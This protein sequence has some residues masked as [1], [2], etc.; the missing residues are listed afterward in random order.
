[1]LGGCRFHFSL[2]VPHDGFIAFIFSGAFTAPTNQVVCL[3]KIE[4]LRLDRTSACVTEFTAFWMTK[5]VGSNSNRQPNPA[6]EINKAE[7]NLKL[8]IVYVYQVLYITVP[9]CMSFC[10]IL[11]EPYSTTLQI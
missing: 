10:N 6:T 5:W 11:E 1:M 4:C 3:D 7:V 2:C 8:G 9:H